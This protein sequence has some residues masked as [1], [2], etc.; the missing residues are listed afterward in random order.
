MSYKI[1][2]THTANGPEETHDGSRYI[3][4]FEGSDGDAW[5]LSVD[6]ET[7]TGTIMSNDIEVPA[8]VDRDHPSGG[9]IFDEAEKFWIRSCWM[10]LLNASFPDVQAMFEKEYKNIEEEVRKDIAAKRA[11]SVTGVH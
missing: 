10:S 11:K 8:N 3:S 6:R 5:V 2:A 1:I 4:A 7:L 9:L